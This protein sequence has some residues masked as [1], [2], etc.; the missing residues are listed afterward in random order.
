MALV[1]VGEAFRDSPKDDPHAV[2]VVAEFFEL[3]GAASRN[4]VLVLAKQS[5]TRGAGAVTGA[6]DRYACRRRA[7][8]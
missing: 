1:Q 7:R 4:Q 5:L 2:D 3:L 6:D 8:A